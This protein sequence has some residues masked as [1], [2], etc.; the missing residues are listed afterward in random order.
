LEH[1][2]QES[3]R[4][5]NTVGSPLKM[6]ESDKKDTLYQWKK[7]DTLNLSKTASQYSSINQEMLDEIASN[8]S[9]LSDFNEPREN[10]ILHN[11]STEDSLEK[12]STSD[13]DLLEHIEVLQAS[14]KTEKQRVS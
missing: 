13:H 3:Y 10:H 4:G 5:H 14:L 7:Y 12:Q 2:L 8:I 1:L 11:S 9:S 6:T